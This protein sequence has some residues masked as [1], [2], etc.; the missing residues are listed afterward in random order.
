MRRQE[1]FK[2]GD[3]VTWH[4]D[5]GEGP[6]DR[7]GRIRVVLSAQYIVDC[8]GTDRFVM[9]SDATLQPYTYKEKGK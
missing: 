5:I 3:R 8:G 7:T 2:V 9:K 1:G 4:D 6:F